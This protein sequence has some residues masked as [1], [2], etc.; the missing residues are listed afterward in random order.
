MEDKR[1]EKTVLCVFGERKR[2]VVFQG[3]CT[4]A[5]E[6]RK[7]LMKAIMASFSDVLVE[8]SR[9]Y[10]LQ[11]ESAEWG[12]L[13]DLSGLVEDRSTVHLCYT[14]SASVEAGESSSEVCEL[15]LDANS[16]L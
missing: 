13:I 4:N 2:P 6:D 15:K 16:Q 10:F 12:G 14:T 8:T 3:S 9:S 11:R 1:E 5:A 7:N